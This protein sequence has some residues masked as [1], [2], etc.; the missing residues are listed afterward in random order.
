MYGVEDFLPPRKGIWILRCRRHE[1]HV[2]NIRAD[3]LGGLTGEGSG[4]WRFFPSP[5]HA[6]RFLGAFRA[7]QL[8]NIREHG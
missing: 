1:V 8:V 7:V 3:G 4:N 2:D 5:G 6:P